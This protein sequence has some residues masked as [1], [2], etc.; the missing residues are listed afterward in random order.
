MSGAELALLLFS[1]CNMVRVLAYLPQIFTIAAD[2]TGAKAVSC[3]TWSLFAVSH[4]SAVAYALAALQDTAM[5]AI[6]SGN[7]L[8]CLVIVGLTLWKRGRAQRKKPR[9][10]RDLSCPTIPPLR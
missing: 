10:L 5:A 4:L 7:A 6:F 8:A 1:A 9:A 3:T 2:A